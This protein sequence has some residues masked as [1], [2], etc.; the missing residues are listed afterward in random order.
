MVASETYLAEEAIELASKWLAAAEADTT[1]KEAERM[2]LL[3]KLINDPDGISFAMNF[4]DLVARPE[5]HEVAAQQLELL[6]SDGAPQ[7]LSPVD[8]IMFATGARM[9]QKLSGVVIP[10]AVKRMKSIVGNLVLDSRV[11]KLAKDLEKLPSFRKNVNLLGEAVLGETEATRRFDQVLR[12][13]KLPEVDYVSVKIS[14][15]ASKL[16]YWDEEGSFKRISDRLAE[17]CQA[18][19]E[20]DPR[21]FINLDME[22]YHDLRLTIR[23][24][25]HVLGQEKFSGLNAGIVLQTYLPDSYKAL[26]DLTRWANERFDRSGGEVKIRLVKGANLAMEKVEAEVHGWAQA[27]YQTKAQV[28][29]N[30]KRCIDWVLTMERCKGVRIGI[31][32]HNLFDVAWA[33][34]VAKDRRVAE[35][36]EFEMLQGMAPAQSRAVKKDSESG[37]LVYTP[38]VDPKDF[39]VAIGYLFRRL[40]ENSTPGNF[41]RSLLTIKPGSPEFKD[42]SKRF[43]TAV[44]ER[45]TVDSTQHRMTQLRPAKAAAIGASD[46]F[47]N[48]PDSDPSVP[49]NLEWAKRIAETASR[50]LE[51]VAWVTEASKVDSVLSEIETGAASWAGL[52]VEERVLRINSVGNELAARRGDLIGAMMAETNKT[53]AQADSEV[54]EAIDFA[55]YYARRSKILFQRSEQ[56]P[57]K[58][59]PFGF[60]TVAP[61]WNFPVAIPAG[62]VLAS[63]A[64]GNAVIFKPAPQAVNCARIVAECCW[65][66]GI[67]NKV[68]RFLP[69]QDGDASKHLISNSQ[70]VILTGAS[71]TSR[72]FQQW[73]PSAKL[74]AETSGKNAIVVTPAAD[75]DQAVEGIAYSAFGHSGQK[76]SAASILISVDGACETP[77]FVNQLKDAV[78]GYAIGDATDLGSDLAHVVLPVAGN[79]QRALTSLDPGERWLVKPENLNGDPKLWAPGVKTG[80]RPGSWFSQTECFGPVLGIIRAKNLDEAIKIQNSTDYGLTGGLYSLNHEEIRT[81]MSKVEVGNAYVN[82]PTTGAIVQRQPF[83]GWKKSNVGP[84]AKA[85]G[86]NYLDQLGFWED[87]ADTKDADWLERAKASDLAAW[88]SEYSKSHDPTGLVSELNIFRY[89]RCKLVAICAGEQTSAIEL[90]RVKHAAEVCGVS[91]EVFL[92]ETGQGLIHKLA[93][94]N[95]SSLSLERMIVLGEVS[96][97][98]VLWASE[99]GVYL[100]SRSVTIEGRLEL[101]RFLKEQ[102]V[103][104]TNHRFGNF[105]NQIEL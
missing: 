16:N 24:F 21:T 7:F 71:E 104:I 95:N 13:I 31:A 60:V 8:R 36:V 1:D 66:A 20:S 22:E 98:L 93:E 15:V 5:N 48:E 32:S 46:T 90:E 3:T 97:D 12:L 18:S 27:P 58:F 10:T 30:Y 26:V 100:D 77:R 103:S 89:Q 28:D 41:M 91:V 35:R 2:G 51:D 52:S 40:E 63:L 25:K 83:G 105:T 101:R 34:L 59:T 65:A 79:L 70:A 75:V 50:Q 17:L 42:E 62:G 37:L 55:T 92:A 57:T 67:G 49:A 45:L 72:M 43:T 47:V 54:S 84:G 9:S 61:P 73:N 99:E 56:G 64:A 82:K 78:Q 38:V 94:L 68:L 102:A 74:F 23:A 29:A 69:M 44:A 33:L 39:D 85:G 6:S 96:E 86:P 81:W 76:C 87:K 11:S 53:F 88:E 14:S 19:L 80:V 4:I